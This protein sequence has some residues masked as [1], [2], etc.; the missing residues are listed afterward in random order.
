M[1]AMAAFDLHRR[2]RS[3]LPTELLERMALTFRYMLS[4]W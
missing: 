2:A 1:K 3:W 4:S